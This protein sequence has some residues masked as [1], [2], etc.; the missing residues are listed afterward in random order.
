[1]KK[2]ASM[3]SDKKLFS[4]TLQLVLALGALAAFSV[5][6]A[7]SLSRIAFGSCAAEDEPQPIWDAIN[8]SQPDLWIWAG[9]NIYGDTEDMTIMR[10]KYGLLAAQPGYRQ[11]VSSGIPILATWDDHDF[12]VNDGGADYAQRKASQQVFL[13]FFDV[14]PDDP[15]RD[16]EGIYHS[17]IH[18]EVGRRVQI[19]MLDTRFHRSPLRTYPRDDDSQPRVY[20]PDSDPAATILGEDQ[21]Q[22]LKRQL[23]KPAELRLIVSS[24]QILASEHRF[25][26]W[27]NFPQER[28]RFL[29]LLKETQAEGVILLSGDRHHAELSRLD[30]PDFYPLFDLTSSG[31]NKSQPRTADDEARPAEPNRYRVGRTFRGHHYGMIEVTWEQPDP[32]IHLNIVDQNGQKPISHVVPLSTLSLNR[33]PGP[34]LRSLSSGSALSEVVETDLRVDGRLDDWQS[35]HYMAASGE[36][37]FIRFPLLEP[38]TLTRSPRAIHIVVD[39]DGEDT[40]M[41]HFLEPGTDMEIV[42]SPPREPGERGWRPSINAYL[43]DETILVAADM[44]LASGPSHAST[45]SELRLS[46]A[47][48]AKIL[49]ASGTGGQAGLAVYAHH[50]DSDSIEVLA[51]DAIA[52]SDV[53][54]IAP[55]T[56]RTATIPSPPDGALRVISWNTLWGSQLETPEPFA[57]VIQALNPDIFLFQEWSRDRLT[58]KQVTDWFKAHIDGTVAWH[59]MVSGAAGSWSG[60]LIVSRY[61]LKGRIPRNTPV[62]GGGWDFPAR[63]AAAVADTP[64][65]EVLLSSLHLK[66]SG[67][68]D[69]PEDERR[70]AEADAINRILIGMSSVAQPDHV[71]LGGDFNLLGDPAVVDRVG[72]MLDE[73]G[74]PLTRIEA[75]V[76]GDPALLYTF[77]REG[78]RSRLDY[79]TYSD[80]SLQVSNAFVLD[81]SILDRSSLNAMQLEST[82][83]GASDH[84]PLVVDLTPWPK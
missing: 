42:F 8:A 10:E 32:L 48:L 66:A 78:L 67:A 43:P 26:K 25:E 29:E 79:L 71:V 59:S 7:E 37:L 3:V 35:D 22:W 75:P 60:T 45:W 21:W 24:I 28:R 27:M 30:Q 55:L 15:R 36:H 58:E 76:L 18:G 63:V 50:K 2:L 56:S 1:M 57:R 33:N 44:D 64:I 40:G 39:F 53:R 61:P 12:G 65:G 20:W 52:L 54:E 47:K 14:A 74:S 5:S 83:T 11:L 19:I 68:I 77:G 13:D 73:D 38:T 49:P 41:D 81:T 70:F 62:E 16:R 9:D 84:L 34:G 82:D 4:R 80:H 23:L 17:E 72:R 69:T 51:S 46:R 6:H 31:L